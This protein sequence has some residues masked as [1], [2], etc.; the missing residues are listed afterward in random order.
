MIQQCPVC[1]AQKRNN[2]FYCSR[3]ERNP[4][5]T[6][7]KDSQ[8]ETVRVYDIP[9]MPDVQYTR[10]CKHAKFEG[11]INSSTTVVPSETFEERSQGLWNTDLYM[12]M[13][14]EITKD[15]QL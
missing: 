3:V 5:L 4:D 15:L 6:V 10:I 12:D 8:G 14:K 2:I 11:C 1:G 9:Y 13:A 7:M